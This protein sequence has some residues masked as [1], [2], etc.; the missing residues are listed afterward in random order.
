MSTTLSPSNA[1]ALKS[2]SSFP[3]STIK[4]ISDGAFAALRDP[5]TGQT[6]P[7]DQ[8]NAQIGLAT[9][10]A[11]FVRQGGVTDSLQSVL[12]DSG[13]ASSVVGHIVES[14]KQ[15]VDVLRAKCANVALSY[16][17]IVGCDWRLDF[18]VS[19]S[20][21]GPSLL[22][23]FF[24]KLLLEGGPSIDFTCTEEE[25]TALVATLKDAAS[26]AARISQ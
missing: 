6:L 1:S 22:P 18:T 5:A 25:M 2:L 21:S 9:L 15:T 13:V 26:E 8:A 10:L 23:I 12:K 17:R 7:P 3:D 19:N 16:N 24:V 20:E 14:Y 4:T 11:I